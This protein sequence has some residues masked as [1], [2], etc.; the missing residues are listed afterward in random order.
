MVIFFPVFCQPPFVRSESGGGGVMVVEGGNKIMIQSFSL[1][2][3]CQQ[4]QLTCALFDCVCV[5]E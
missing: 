2:H 5:K 3:L 1:W 4:Q